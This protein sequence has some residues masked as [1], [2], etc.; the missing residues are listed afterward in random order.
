MLT[1]AGQWPDR[2]RLKATFLPDDP[3]KEFNRQP[4]R[5]RRRVDHLT[6]GI[7]RIAQLLTWRRGL[8][9]RLR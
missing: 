3:Y 5:S 8:R 9:R 4:A 7:G 2:V 1:V 6:N